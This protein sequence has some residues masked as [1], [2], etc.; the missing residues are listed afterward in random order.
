MPFSDS[1]A[2][3]IL[4]YTLGKTK[5][6]TAPSYVYLGLSSNDPVA[7][8]GTFTELS[9]GNYSRVLIVQTGE[10]YP[11]VIGSASG[12]SI[13]NVKQI[14]WN[15]ATADW[16]TAKGWGLFTAAT[17]GS[18]FFYAKL[19]A[20]VT[21]PQ[22]AVALFEPAGFGLNFPETDAVTV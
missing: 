1:Y 16:L 9:G 13:D 7:D 19:D 17:G 12:R 20:E 11:D 15:K 10:A 2:N 4:S 22:G 8:G 6:L 5:T 14:N 18:P 3:Q 21:V